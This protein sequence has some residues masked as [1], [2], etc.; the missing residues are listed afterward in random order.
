MVLTLLEERAVQAVSKTNLFEEISV[1]QRTSGLATHSVALKE[2]VSW[3]KELEKTDVNAFGSRGVSNQMWNHRS[4]LIP[5]SGVVLVVGLIC[6]L[7]LWQRRRIDKI[8]TS[9][10]PVK[11]LHISEGQ[12]PEKLESVNE[13]CVLETPSTH[14]IQAVGRVIE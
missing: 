3:A 14:A 10:G 9:H 6:G 13:V 4:T 12:V 7:W 11:L 1:S 5:T 8:T 2:V